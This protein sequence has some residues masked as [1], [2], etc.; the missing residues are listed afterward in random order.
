M[1]EF[2]KENPDWTPEGGSPS[3]E[4]LAAATPPVVPVPLDAEGNPIAQGN[5][6]TDAPPR[7]LYV[8]RKVT[9]GA[10]IVAW[11]KAQGFETTLDASD[12]HVTVAFSRAPVD[13]MKAGSDWTSR[14]DG[15]LTIKP[16]GARLLEKFDGGA[17]VLLFN[18][19]DLSWRHQSIKDAGAT[20]DFPDY[21]PHITITYAPGALDLSKVEPYRG[22]IELG[23]EVFSELNEDWKASVQET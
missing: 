4:E 22:T 17:I 19:S 9:N 11:A 5:Q 8:H 16:G 12:M 15:G 2:T 3:E 1:D 10:D 18:S 23:P 20:W 6:V 21:Q 14:E 7:T 13:W